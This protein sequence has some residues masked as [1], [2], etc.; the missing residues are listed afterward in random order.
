ML[1]TSRISQIVYPGS[2]LGYINT[3]YSDVPHHITAAVVVCAHIKDPQHTA[4]IR[5]PTLTFSVGRLL[6]RR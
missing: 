5:L 2:L 4:T 1:P 3:K 6:M